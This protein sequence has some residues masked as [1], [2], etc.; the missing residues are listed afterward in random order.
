MLNRT[1]HL[2]IHNGIKII[3][4]A[5]CSKLRTT[6]TAKTKCLPAE[7]RN[8]SQQIY[9]LNL[10]FYFLRLSANNQELTST[11]Q[12]QMNNFCCHWFTAR[13]FATK[14]LK[15]VNIQNTVVTVLTKYRR[16]PFSFLYRTTSIEADTASLAS[17]CSLGG[18]FIRTAPINSAHSSNVEDAHRCSGCVSRRWGMCYHSSPPFGK[19]TIWIFNT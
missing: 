3:H 11:L 10:I 4:H 2:N 16:I 12:I 13:E 9:K 8:I 6:R 1:I 5:Q 14:K 7:F 15:R 17:L 18:T 19:K